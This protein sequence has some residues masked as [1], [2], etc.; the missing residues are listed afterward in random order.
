MFKPAESVTVIPYVHGRLSFTQQVRDAC[1][2]SRF[3]C[4]AVDAPACL[5]EHL[6]DAIHHLPHISTVTAQD[7]GN[8]VYFATADPCD[9]VIEALRQSR[10][11]H[12]DCHCIGSPVLFSPAPLPSLP[13][14]HAMGQMGFDAYVSLC[15]RVIGARG[16]P[17][18]SFEPVNDASSQYTAHLLL[19]L[20]SR[21]KNILALI[22]M[23]AL[24]RV[25]HH[26][27]QERSFNLTFDAPP[28]Y[29]INRYFVNPDH[30]YFA[31][32]ELPFVTGKFEAE[33]Y[34]PFSPRVNAVDCLKS[35]F[36][37]TRDEY[38]SP[39]N[40]V[41]LLSTGR[42]QRGLTFLRNLTL[43]DSRFVPSLSDIVAAAKGVGGN[44]YALHV[45][46]TARYYPYLPFEL[47]EP[48]ASIG[49]D[50]ILLPGESSARPAV[51]LFRDV[52]L[53]W[54][55]IS[56][57]PDPSIA[58]R[59]SYRFAWNPVSACSHVPE[60][61]RI[62][63]FNAHVRN[64][65]HKIMCEDK[66]VSEK[67]TVSVK[68]GI[69]IRETMRNWFTSDIYVREVPPSQGALDTVVIIFDEDHDE[70]YPQCATWYAEHPEE[71]TL[72]FYATDPLADLVGPGIARSY[73]G[74]L[75]LLFPP[76]MIPDVFSLPDPPDLRTRAEMLAWGGLL[77]SQEQAVAY[78]AAKKPGV[79]LRRLAASC[80]KRLV[81]IPLSSFGGETLRR[82]R[83]FHILNGKTVRSWATR[84][85]GEIE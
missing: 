1:L 20:A 13:D 61:E 40:D 53:A 34:N 33:R 46:S 27:R 58:A 48:L 35:L 73:Y 57:R 41:V 2:A 66:A 24:G 80:K 52:S 55:T 28:S 21:Y 38:R 6:L 75:S 49:I 36:T 67:F 43:L 59:H 81:W 50:K 26:F 44:S 29:S 83:K 70:R 23:G 47:G 3:D 30:L 56:L 84:F 39:E 68:D 8:T 60:D 5:Q 45:L 32:G 63:R 65:A 64:K 77:F 72:T 79:R 10:Q 9:P 37:E 85:I 69:D 82:L 18:D 19:S 62:E 54:R 31:L 51:N 22:H 78:V 4:I 17:K 42:M 16:D 15:L 76:R 14:D 71:S 12:V 11:N 25:L 7:N 74:G